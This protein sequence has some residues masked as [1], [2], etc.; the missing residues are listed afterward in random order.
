MAQFDISLGRVCSHF[1]SLYPINCKKN[2]LLSQRK[3][4]D[5][6]TFVLDCPRS[7]WL[8]SSTSDYNWR[9]HCISWRR[10]NRRIILQTKYPLIFNKFE[11]Q[12]III[13]GEQEGSQKYFLYYNFIKYIHCFKTYKSSDKLLYFFLMIF[14]KNFP[15]ECQK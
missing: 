3:N 12:K 14:L 5:D 15:R 4:K 11:L 7:E 6:V 8:K 9:I 13:G 2:L 1:Y 10:E